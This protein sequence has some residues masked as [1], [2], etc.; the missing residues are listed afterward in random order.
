VGAAPEPEPSQ[1]SLQAGDFRHV[2]LDLER[3]RMPPPAERVELGQQTLQASQG[4][5]NW[6]Q[7]KVS[8]AKAERERPE[9]NLG[10]IVIAKRPIGFPAK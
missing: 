1:T 5:R 6:S 7:G 3:E 9:K 2:R 10:A 8:E 4:G